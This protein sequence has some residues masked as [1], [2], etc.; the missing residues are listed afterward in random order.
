MKRPIRNGKD[1]EPRRNDNRIQW[2]MLVAS[3][4][5]LAPGKRF[6]QIRVKVDRAVGQD[7]K[8]G[9]YRHEGTQ[10]YCIALLLS[11]PSKKRLN[12]YS[13]AKAGD[14]RSRYDEVVEA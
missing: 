7:L 8:A 11:A 3:G 9:P 10:Q 5:V 1:R 14:H 2:R 6:N 4:Q 13:I 12:K